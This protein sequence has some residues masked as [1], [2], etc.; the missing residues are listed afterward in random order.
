MFANYNVLKNDSGFILLTYDSVG[1]MLLKQGPYG[2]KPVLQRVLIVTPSSLVVNWQNE[3]L[4]WLGRERIQTFVVDQVIPNF[5][6]V[7]WV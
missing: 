1:R 5:Y 2:G 4:H 7:V 3:F 6:C